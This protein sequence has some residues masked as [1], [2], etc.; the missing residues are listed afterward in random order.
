MEL[1]LVTLVLEEFVGVEEL[2]FEVLDVVLTEF[3]P[4]AL[5][6]EELEVF[7]FI[8]E[9]SDAEFDYLY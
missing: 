8:A 4:S 5:L 9:L 1:V 6:A 3:E 2:V 7:V